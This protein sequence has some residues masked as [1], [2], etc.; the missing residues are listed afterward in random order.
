MV[1][2]ALTSPGPLLASAF[3]PPV[4]FYCV[5]EAKT[6]TSLKA[7]PERQVRTAGA[8]H[9]AGEVCFSSPAAQGRT[10]DAG[11]FGRMGSLTTQ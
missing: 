9:S 11:A 6:K 4:L 7:S 8:K 2:E 3:A 1:V 10:A 5:G